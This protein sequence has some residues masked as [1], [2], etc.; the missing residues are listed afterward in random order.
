MRSKS[1][2]G[3]V[4]VTVL[5]LAA[6]TFFAGFGLRG[7]YNEFAR[8]SRG[9]IAGFPRF[10]SAAPRLSDPDL[11][12]AQV[13]IEVFQKLKAFYVD[14]LPSDSDM[15][16]GSVDMMLAR[17][18]D[19]NTRLLTKS[20][21]DAQR[22]AIQGQFDGLGAVLTIRRYTENG[23]LV[24]AD[25]PAA[26]PPKPAPGKAPAERPITTRQL[27][28]VSVGLGSAAE[29]AGLKPGDRITEL[30]GHWIAPAHLSYRLLTQITEPYGPQDLRPRSED[31]SP[32]SNKIPDAEREKIHK[33]Q[34]ELSRKWKGATD[35]HVAMR[36]LAGGQGNHELTIAR[37]TGT[38]TL[39][40]PV[41]LGVMHGDVFSS[42]KLNATTGYIAVRTMNGDTVRSA[43]DALSGFQRDGLK[44]LVV[45]LRNSAG[46]SI[47]VARDLAGLIMGNG[48]FAILKERDAD[49]KLVEHPL[50]VTGA[51]VRFKPTVL[52]VLV[53]GGTAGS[54]ELVAAALR[55][56]A[57]ARLVGTTTFGDGT[58]QDLVQ[59][60]NGAG[61]SIT[62]AYMLTSKGVD[63]DGKGIPADV[64]PQGDPLETAVKALSTATGKGA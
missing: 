26:D 19:P 29:K 48:R 14:P 58:E 40:V 23:D 5:I 3:W 44:N 4:S 27:T 16:A 30:D 38:A 8:V 39:K 21:V 20:E 64:K 32:D 49:R 9:G 43:E 47:E 6:F 25:D 2:V 34:D 11:K 55:D 12:P 18:D 35:T 33:E 13:Y 51:T 62:R 7:V 24:R 57:G 60:E 61:V 54:S 42:R 52:T 1:P 63:Y 37:G 41:T 50:M 59:L 28:V 15:A 36:L 10:A 56:N 17:L 31:E 22:D 45:D 46:G 53:D